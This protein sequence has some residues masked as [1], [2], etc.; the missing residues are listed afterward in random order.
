MTK[1]EKRAEKARRRGSNGGKRRIPALPQLPVILV[2]TEGEETEPVYLD[3]LNRRV[4]GVNIEVC[5][6]KPNPQDVVQLAISE[7]R[8][9]PSRARSKGDRGDTYDEVW[10]FVDIDTHPGLQA[11]LD[12]E[13]R[14]G[15]R[16]AVSGLCFETWLLMHLRDQ[17]R[18]YTRSSDE[19]KAWIAA[20]GGEGRE[21]ADRIEALAD[22][23]P[24]ALRRA[25]SQ[26]RKHERDGRRRTQRNPS[27]EVA[28]FIRAI[29]ARAKV[30]PERLYNVT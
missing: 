14:E 29:A 26:L 24:H 2:A 15:L 3:W 8:M 17:T 16:I 21:E 7:R 11:A 22:G 9:G 4:S 28:D 20:T 1:R 6:R 13:Q 12:M 30:E 5:F 10:C 18:P 19:K 27:S 25:D 23:L